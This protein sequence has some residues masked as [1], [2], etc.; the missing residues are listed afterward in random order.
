MKR[1]AVATDPMTA[2]QENKFKEALGGGVLWWHWLP[3]FWL[4]KDTQ[5]RHTAASIRDIVF[6]T[7][8]T[9]RTVVLEIERS[10]WAAL[11]KKDSQ[12]RNMSDWL[13]SDWSS[14]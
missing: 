6:E 12:G 11:T 13:H 2:A 7:N 10:Q 9:I 5:D 3:N 4:L 8:N 14:N 1:F